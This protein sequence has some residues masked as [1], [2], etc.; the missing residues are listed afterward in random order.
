MNKYVLMIIAMAMILAGIT[1]FIYLHIN[2]DKAG[3]VLLIATTTSL[4]QT[5]VLADLLSAFN[6]ETGLNVRFHFVTRGSGEVLRLLADG[7]VCIG[8]T[9]APAL[10][11]EYINEGKVARLAIFAYNEFIL[12]GP[13]NDPAGVNKASDVLEAFKRIYEAGEKGLLVFISRGDTSGTHLME[14]TIWRMLGLN[15]EGKP[16]YYR[17]SQGMYQALIIANNL[18]GYVLTDEGTFTTMKREGKLEYLQ[19]LLRDMEHLLNIY[20]MYVSKNNACDNPSIHWISLKLRDFLLTRGQ[21]ILREKYSGVLNP[22][23][24]NEEMFLDKWKKLASMQMN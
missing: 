1:P 21:D 17:V 13:L 8:F 7:S 23:K 3:D 24:G 9:H 5:G 18:R 2:V 22:V 14:L 11:A 19:P 20:S 12:V 6:E 10:E 16:W 15:P 4:H